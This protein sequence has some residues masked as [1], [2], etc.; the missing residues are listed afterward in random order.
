MK[1]VRRIRRSLAR[2]LSG[3][4]VALLRRIRRGL[5]LL[6]A[7]F[8][9]I[10]LG[11]VLLYG[12]LPPPVTPLMVMRVVEGEALRKEWRAY[13]EIS[14]HLVQAVLAS[15][16]SRFC[17]HSGFDW[18]A[19]RLALARNLEGG[20]TLGASTISMQTAKN[21]FLWPARTYLR[22]GL[23][24]YFTVLIE[25]FWN[26]QRIIETYVNVAEWGH[27]I[28]GAEAAAQAHFGKSADKL[29]R[30]E[31]ALLAAVLPNP[32]LWSAS[33]PTRYIERRAATIQARMRIM[34][35]PGARMCG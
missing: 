6:A 10:S 19:L 7:G 33:R 16:D 18:T 30:R 35:A 31:A 2:H 27:G 1:F 26:K 34:P 17:E 25:L 3:F 12:V 9:L 5:I 21:V 8:F 4:A 29:T 11:F 32:R 23:E 24:A 14:P 20:Q 15:E 22:K 13:D 28:Y